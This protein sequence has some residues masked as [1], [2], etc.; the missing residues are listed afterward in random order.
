MILD[1]NGYFAPPATGGLSLYTVTPCRVIDTRNG[2]GAFDGTLTVPVET[3]VCAAPAAAQAYVVNATVVPP[4]DLGYLSLWSAGAA[5]PYV[6]TLNASDGAITSNMA[7]VP[8]T[9]GSVDAYSSNPT[10]LILDLSSYFAP[11]PSVATPI[12][13]L[14]AGTY[15]GAQTV[16]ISDAT[17]GSTIYYTTDGSTPT[18]SSTKYAGA[19]TVSATETVNAIAVL[20]GYNNS[21]VATAAYTLVAATPTFSPVA[22]TYTSVQT[23]TISDAT[24]GSTIYYTTDGTTPTASSTKYA[25][26]ITVSATETLNAIATASGYSN[27]AVATAAYTISQGTTTDPETGIST[28]IV[29]TAT[30]PTALLSLLQ[31]GAQF[32]SGTGP[33]ALIPNPDPSSGGIWSDPAVAGD[34]VRISSTATSFTDAFTVANRSAGSTTFYAESRTT[35]TSTSPATLTVKPLN[36]ITEP[37]AYNANGSAEAIKMVMAGPYNVVAADNSATVKAIVVNKDGSYGADTV[38]APNTPTTANVTNL[39]IGNDTAGNAVVVVERS[40]GL[41]NIYGNQG[42]G[43]LPVWLA[44]VP[45]GVVVPNALTATPS[46]AIAANVDIVSATTVSPSLTVPIAAFFAQTGASGTNGGSLFFQPPTKSGGQATVSPGDVA[47]P[48]GNGSFG[49]NIG[50]MSIP[51]PSGLPSL[52]VLDQGAGSQS[53]MLWTY[54]VSNNANGLSASSAGSAVLPFNPSNK[55]K[56]SL[57]QSTTDFILA[58]SDPTQSGTYTA[59]KNSDGTVGTPAISVPANFSA[60]TTYLLPDYGNI[61][62][63]FQGSVL[64]LNSSGTPVGGLLLQ[65]VR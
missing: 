23:V 32:P 27:S 1:V 36:S 21:A 53:G 44:E 33:S 15:I 10:Q 9:N 45:A 37:F 25:G 39:W 16:G 30:V 43:G 5:Q 24:A 46:S 56:I 65:G 2:A 57:S 31:A 42:N 63:G 48:N 59:A 52:G 62:N 13:S 6:S 54:G 3:S 26:A 64:V 58:S 19:I 12:F 51:Q 47:S 8:T 41:A 22:G 17:T 20:S 60:G 38:L 35:D 18:A 4:G 55:G 14:A 50:F 49:P 61:A 7:I 28:V 29:N 34:G 40:N 11:A